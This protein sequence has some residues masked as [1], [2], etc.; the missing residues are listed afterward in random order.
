MGHDAAGAEMARSALGRLR[1]SDRLAEH[2]ASLTRN[3]LRLGFLVHHVPL[4]RRAVYR[5]MRAC[6]PVEVDVSLLS[7]ADRLATRG[8][9]SE[10]AITRHLDLARELVGEG[11]AWRSRPPRPPLR[12]DQLA[13]AIGLPPGP[14][15]GQ[16]LRELEEASFAGEIA[17][18]DEAIER[19][20]AL[21]AGRGNGVSDR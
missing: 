17:S 16:I 15:I 11:L 19:A 14:E 2:V 6:E 3:H 20:R 4:S 9:N 12:G 21:V 13:R 10:I 7:V 8:K 1:T 5:Y 18:T